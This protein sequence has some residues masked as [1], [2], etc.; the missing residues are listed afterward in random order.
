MKLDQ[1]KKIIR[2]ECKEAF[3]E[4]LKGILVEALNAKN[5]IIV[6]STPLGNTT[7]PNVVREHISKPIPDVRNRYSQIL[8]ETFNSSFTNP[9]TQSNGYVPS[10][11]DIIGGDLGDGEVSVDQI[12]A[13]FK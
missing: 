7:T 6:Q 4:E 10:G 11:G 8:E 1:L 5:N 2:E 12:N 3:R 13:L 9:T